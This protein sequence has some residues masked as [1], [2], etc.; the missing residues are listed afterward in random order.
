MSNGFGRFYT[1]HIRCTGHIAC[2]CPTLMLIVLAL[3]TLPYGPIP[4]LLPYLD[5][6][7]AAQKKGNKKPPGFHLGA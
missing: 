2:G 3:H 5:A 4:Y 7:S 6:D 1:D